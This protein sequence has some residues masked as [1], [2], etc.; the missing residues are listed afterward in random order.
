MFSLFSRVKIARF[1]LYITFIC[2][3]ITA[4]SILSFGHAV[5]YYIEQEASIANIL[6]YIT[7]LGTL[8][9]V[10]SFGRSF[11]GSKF[12][13]SLISQLQNQ[14][15]QIAIDSNYSD[16]NKDISTQFS[17]VLNKDLPYIQDHMSNFAF[18]TIRNI[19]ISL[20][21]LIMLFVIHIPMTLIILLCIIFALCIIFPL[22]KGISSM[23]KIIE[24]K[25]KELVKTSS[26]R[27]DFL[28]IVK[29]FETAKREKDIFKNISDEISQYALKN[30]FLK[31]LLVG[32]IMFTIILFIGVIIFFGKLSIANES[33][34]RGEF[35]SYIFYLILLSVAISAMSNFSSLYISMKISTKNIL[36]FIDNFSEDVKIDSDIRIAQSI[37]KIEK[38]EFSNIVIRAM[39]EDLETH[40]T[41]ISNLSFSCKA[42]DKI[43]VI[44]QSGSGKSSFIEFLCGY[45]DWSG[46]IIVNNDIPIT[47]TNELLCHIT[48]S[49][50]QSRLFSNLNVNSNIEY[51]DNIRNDILQEDLNINDFL[52]HDSASL[53]GGEK[54]RVSNSRAIMKKASILLF[55]EPTSFLDNIHEEKF[56]EMLYKYRNSDS[57]LICVSHKLSHVQEFDKVLFFGNDKIIFDKHK[58]LLE[59]TEEYRRLFG[60]DSEK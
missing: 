9:S 46:D 20:F 60:Y 12:T 37:E 55:D 25:Q 10:S 51:A 16:K 30:A 41:L 2:L 4:L 47:N 39:N 50:Q 29:I 58:S 42:G 45:Y 44:G 3:V 17:A 54:Q 38:L 1:E 35:S 28:N 19:I 21:S 59:N 24:A 22:A 40:S 13:L 23:I 8:L 11:F 49:G 5:G 15:Y 52:L 36:S 56:Y 57:I 32:V 31:A 6:L 43:M 34:S 26:E 48:M 18:F 33:L 53:S 14:V 7:I 27:L